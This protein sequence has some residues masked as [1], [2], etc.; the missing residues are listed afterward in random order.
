[1]ARQVCR[2]RCVDVFI[3]GSSVVSEMGACG[4]AV[5]QRF[6]YCTRFTGGGVQLPSSIDGAALRGW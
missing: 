6:G 5:G 2:A 4:I 1:M 3:V